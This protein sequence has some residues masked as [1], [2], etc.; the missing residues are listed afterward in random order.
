MGVKRQWKIQKITSLPISEEV[1]HQLITDIMRRKRPSVHVYAWDIHE[2]VARKAFLQQ[3]SA[4]YDWYTKKR[5]WEVEEPPKGVLLYEWS[6]PVDDVLKNSGDDCICNL[7][8]SKE[9]KFHV[10]ISPSDLHRDMQ[11]IL[12]NEPSKN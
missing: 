9:R 7:A 3:Q 6:A 10:G 8:V 4:V 1:R 5:L 12:K 11:R 2:G